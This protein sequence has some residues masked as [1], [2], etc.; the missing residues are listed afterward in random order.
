MRATHQIL[1]AVAL[2]T[3][4]CSQSSAAQT[5]LQ[6]HIIWSIAH[7][8]CR[9]FSGN[10]LNPTEA[11]RQCFIAKETGNPDAGNLL[12]TAPADKLLDAVKESLIL[13]YSEYQIPANFE[14][15]LSHERQLELFRE[16]GRSKD[17]EQIRA[18][19]Y[20]KQAH[21][22]NAKYALSAVSDAQIQ[23]L[24]DTPRLTV[25]IDEATTFEQLAQIDS[26]TTST[27][28]TTASATTLGFLLTATY[29]FSSTSVKRIVL[30][31]N[32][33]FPQTLGDPAQIQIPAGTQ[34]TLPSIPRI[35]EVATV[36]LRPSTGI[37]TCDS[38]LCN[39][40]DERV[41]EIAHLRAEGAQVE[42]EIFGHIESPAGQLQSVS[43]PSAADYGWY[44]NWLGLDSI[45]GA[46]LH[47]GSQVA[48]AVVDSGADIDHPDLKPS[49]WSTPSAVADARWPAGAPGYDFLRHTAEPR[50]ENNDSHGTHVSGLVVGEQ[51]SKWKTDFGQ[52]LGHYL[53][54]VELKVAGSHNVVDSGTVQNAIV[55]GVG[56][57]V[58]IF[59]CSFE[60]GNESEMLR[61]YVKSDD[62]RANTLFVIAAGNYGAISKGS[63]LDEDSFRHMTFRGDDGIPFSDVLLVAALDEQGKIASFSNYGPKTVAIAAPGNNI[64]STTRNN[65]YGLLAGSSQA[66]P[67]VTLTAAILLSELP[68]LFLPEIRQRI[69]DTCDWVPE[70]VPYV[71]DGCRLNILKATT[72]NTD[73]IQLKSGVMIKGTVLAAQI[74][75]STANP[76]SPK[77]E[78]VWFDD[79]SQMTIVTTDGRYSVPATS[80]PSITI[81]LAKPSDCTGQLAGTSCVIQTSTVRDIVFRAM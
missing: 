77:Y 55:G 21:N 4:C 45:E 30:E 22:P 11:M 68:S 26:L 16:L 12:K 60:L 72:V 33:Q 74:P 38:G 52:A 43:Q 18:I 64:S 34:V 76:A 80:L 3:V 59:N 79:N 25:L 36:P 81:Q 15:V 27:A 42:P 49:F 58:R 54:L 44:L 63:N 78:R 47:L 17:Y 57:G 67:F 10:Q 73:L 7:E 65:G 41:F 6:S 24:L 28:T 70:L 31:K 9:A 37:T 20:Q 13:A 5:V 39:I 32:K 19:Y 66:A 75:H 46:D 53:R 23:A 14:W 56:K 62:R 48:I 29:G 71:H 51:I 61:G 2:G 1:L 50:D 40:V 35:G 8:G 69:L